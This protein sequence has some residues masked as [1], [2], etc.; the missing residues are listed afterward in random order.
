MKTVRRILPLFLLLLVA[1]MGTP[2]RVSTEQERALATTTLDAIETALAVMHGTGKIP[3]DHYTQATAQVRDLRS[4]VEA[5]ATT[6]VEPS[7]L[8]QRTL[9]LAAAW[10]IT[11]AR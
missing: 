1:C 5:S 10:S 8:T 11:L 3:T 9:A 6:P 4:F 2:P 7:A